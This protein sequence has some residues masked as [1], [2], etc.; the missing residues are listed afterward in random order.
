MTATP[1]LKRSFGLGLIRYVGSPYIF[2]VVKNSIYLVS[3]AATTV[4]AKINHS[5]CHSGEQQNHQQHAQDALIAK[6]CA[7]LNRHG[8]M[9]SKSCAP[10]VGNLV[11]VFLYVF[12]NTLNCPS[13]GGAPLVPAAEPTMGPSTG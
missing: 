5:V 7:F 4:P 2:S 12:N 6:E 9:L 3:C 8:W 10:S 13:I 1:P 11:R